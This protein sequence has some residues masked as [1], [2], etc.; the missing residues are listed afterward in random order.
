MYNPC[1]SWNFLKEMI[2]ENVHDVVNGINAFED[3][4]DVIQINHN[5]SISKAKFIH[6]PFNYLY[7]FLQCIFIINHLTHQQHTPNDVFE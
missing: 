4:L 6:F 5:F 7:I 1:V 2:K 3:T